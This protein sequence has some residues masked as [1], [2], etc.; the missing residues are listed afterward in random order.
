[1]V[2]EGRRRRQGLHRR[3]G[4][5]ARQPSASCLAPEPSSLMR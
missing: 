2:A 3:P 5:R 4:R 1:M